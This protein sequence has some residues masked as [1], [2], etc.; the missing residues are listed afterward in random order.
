[1]TYYSQTELMGVLEKGKMKLQAKHLSEEQKK[2]I[3]R[4]LT[5]GEGDLAIVSANNNFCKIH[6]KTLKFGIKHI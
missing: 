2:V 1:M 5:K 4:H 3:V 6:Q